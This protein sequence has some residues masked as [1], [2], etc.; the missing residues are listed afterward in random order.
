M[1]ELSP[2][3]GQP[4][5]HW[6]CPRLPRLAVSHACGWDMLVSALLS[7]PPRRTPD[8][9]PWE[10]DP[11]SA[12]RTVFV[13]ASPEA[14]P[15]VRTGALL[16]SRRLWWTWRCPFRSP[17]KEGLIALLS[18]PSGSAPAAERAP[19]CHLR[20][21]LPFLGLLASSCVPTSGA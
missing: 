19:S 5:A 18:A 7:S 1:E 4:E 9:V 15:Q 21:C 14:E 6:A 3:G 2:R 13:W 12:S 16:V 20:S 17:F 10:P 11:R 8:S